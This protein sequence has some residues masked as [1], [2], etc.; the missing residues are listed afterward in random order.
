[1]RAHG[2]DDGGSQS[3]RAKGGGRQ[4]CKALGHGWSPD[5]LSDRRTSAGNEVATTTPVD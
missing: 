1:L 2:R 5:G 4:K 3:Q